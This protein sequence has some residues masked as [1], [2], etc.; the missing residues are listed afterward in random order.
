LRHTPTRPF[1]SSDL[2]DAGEA[3]A[4]LRA[5]LPSRSRRARRR[6]THRVRRHPGS[7]RGR[8]T[9]C[10]IEGA[11]LEAKEI[12]DLFRVAR[13]VAAPTPKSALNA[14]AERFPAL[15]GGRKRMGDFRALLKDLEGKIL[16]DGSVGRIMPASLWRGCG[17][18]SSGSASPSKVRSSD[19]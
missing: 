18:I 2:A 6:H 1:L 9:S 7:H 14:V 16:P 17:G 15:A 10:A 13:T 12:L 3:V 11:S 4:F 8:S 5:R 19:S